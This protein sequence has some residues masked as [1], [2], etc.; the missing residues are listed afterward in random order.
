MKHLLFVLSAFAVTLS[1]VQALE[2]TTCKTCH[3][4][5]F[6]EYSRSMHAHASTVRDAV[7]RA[8]WEKHP[9]KQK[10]TY[11]CAQCHT[12]SDHTL[13]NGKGV[14]TDNAVQRTEPISCQ[15]CHRI[16]SIEKHAK[17]NRNILTDKPKS[18]YSADPKRK[19]EKVIFREE[20]RLF[21]LITHTTGSPYH[22][23]DYSNEAYY[24]GK[25]CMGCHSHKQNSRG[26][27]ICDLEVKQGESNATC[28]SCHMPQTSG[29]V[30]NQ[31]RTATHAWHGASIH[32]STPKHL[33]KYVALTLQPQAKGF[34]VTI[35]NKAT[36]T[37]F[38]HPL[39]QGQL[40]VTIVQDG[41]LIAL[42]PRTFARVI[43][44]DGKPSM[45]WLAD[46]VIRDT[47]IKAGEKR[48]VTFDAVLKKGDEVMVEFGYYLVRPANAKALGLEGTP[49]EEF[50]VLKQKRFV[51]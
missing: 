39:R 47:T 3:P 25:M 16:E 41:K 6:A 34:T 32:G 49:A 5:I 30:A 4:K 24:D 9:L 7:H 12:P 44:T 43:G 48:T 17:A 42:P 18:F 14:P 31:K 50:I 15:G 13:S 35:A 19:G 46:R 27:A 11:T 45:P 37:L 8:V 1:A 20:S 23:I 26:F 40:R 10:G 2:N 33:G 36:H 29:A 38:P 51:F 21:G 28:M 22:D